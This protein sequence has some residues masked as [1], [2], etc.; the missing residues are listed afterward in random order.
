MDGV[1]ETTVSPWSV[2]PGWRT[3]EAE[4][5][6]VAERE[7][8]LRC[9]ACSCAAI[10]SCFCCSGGSCKALNWASWAWISWAPMPV[11]K[12][13]AGLVLRAEL[14]LLEEPWEWDWD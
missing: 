9:W 10:R 4:A 14:V 11:S 1:V 7:E 6:R 8:D 2:A 5:G 13:V 3:M 12:V